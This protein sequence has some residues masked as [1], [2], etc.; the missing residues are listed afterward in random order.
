[1]SSAE[2]TPKTATP[3]EIGIVENGLAEPTL[4]PT[5]PNR[6]KHIEMMLSETGPYS[7]SIRSAWRGFENATESVRS[8]FLA[9]LNT[10]GNLLNAKDH[11]AMRAAVDSKSKA[12]KLAGRINRRTLRIFKADYDKMNAEE[13]RK[14]IE[15]KSA[16]IA[17]AFVNSFFRT[18]VWE[19]LSDRTDIKD[20]V[21]STHSIIELLGLIF[22]HP[23][24]RIRFEA[25][26][27]L[28]LMKLAAT[29]DARSEELK[30]KDRFPR[31]LELLNEGFW[32]GEIG[33]DKKKRLK[34]GDV[35][36]ESHHDYATFATIGDPREYPD[37]EEEAVKQRMEKHKPKPGGYY[38]RI[39]QFE[40]RYINYDGE[41]IPVN[42]DS[43]QKSLLSRMGKMIRKEE[44]DPAVA[45]QDTTGLMF[46]VRNIR[47]AYKVFDFFTRGGENGSLTFAVGDVEDTLSGKEKYSA[48]NEGSSPK[49]RQLK[50]IATIEGISVE[51]IIHTYATYLNNLMEDEVAHD[52]LDVRR[53]T[54]TARK[55]F[56]HEIYPKINLEVRIPEMIANQRKVRR[57]S[58]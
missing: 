36:I 44:E 3:A 46:V 52:E 20:E 49:T 39:R 40:Q 1:M 30:E 35:N 8:Q 42:Q 27:K 23:D 7:V 50:F 38:I 13:R 17:D 28:V 21:Q 4:A 48:E 12:E 15:E 47:D 6:M 14:E 24:R 51:V 29:A 22:H 25:K 10:I 33:P 34:T 11:A 31:F 55:I 45:V 16:L 54:A 19:P 32:Y 43:R 56:P 57:V 26:R 58:R 41:L 37:G 5:K 53:H 2:T 18:G 9:D